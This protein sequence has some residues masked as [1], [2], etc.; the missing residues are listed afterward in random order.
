MESI[1]VFAVEMPPGFYY[2]FWNG[3]S[4][5]PQQFSSV[6]VPNMPSRLQSVSIRGKPATY[7]YM[8]CPFT[9]P[10]LHCQLLGLNR[11]PTGPDRRSRRGHPRSRL[12]PTIVRLRDSHRHRE[13]QQKVVNGLNGFCPD[14]I[15]V[16]LHVA[17]L[18]RVSPFH[19]QYVN[20]T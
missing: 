13:L 6:S 5:A 10:A 15:C 12:R 4:A 19:F 7:I 2:D 17:F 11:K 3:L 14:A 9:K 20:S 18:A 16:A 1:C 8:R